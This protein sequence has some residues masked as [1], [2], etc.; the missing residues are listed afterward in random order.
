VHEQDVSR[1]AAEKMDAQTAGICLSC[2]RPLTRR[3]PAGEC[4]RCLMSLALLTDEEPLEEGIARRLPAGPGPLSYAH[5]EV[6]VGGG[7]RSS[8]P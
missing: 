2:G 8:P 7:L 3:G 5:F 6:E 1:E 4:L